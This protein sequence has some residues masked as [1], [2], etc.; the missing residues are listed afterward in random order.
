MKKQYGKNIR[1]KMEEIRKTQIVNEEIEENDQLK[2]E[3][4][5]KL[6]KALI[7]QKRLLGRFYEFSTEHGEF[8]YDELGENMEEGDE[9]L[10]RADKIRDKILDQ[11]EQ[12]L[13]YIFENRDT[14]S[15]TNIISFD[16]DAKQNKY[17]VVIEVSKNSFDLEVV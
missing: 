6:K 16:L 2:D 15:M 1:D 11:I 7:E 3:V 9:L 5:E 13:L 12:E 10:R 8:E 14:N 4:F 17:R